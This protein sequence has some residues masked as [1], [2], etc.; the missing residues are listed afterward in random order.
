MKAIKV[1]AKPKTSRSGRH[2]NFDSTIVL[3][4]HLVSPPPRPDGIVYGNRS[5]Y[6]FTT[7]AAL[8]M[9]VEWDEKEDGRKIRKM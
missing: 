5:V 2:S 7:G 3:N 1:R 8:I 6:V 4:Y 9:C